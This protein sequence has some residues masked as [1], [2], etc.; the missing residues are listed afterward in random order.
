MKIC[1]IYLLFLPI[2]LANCSGNNNNH[3]EV[4]LQGKSYY[5]KGIPN[6]FCVHTKLGGVMGDTLIVKT[7]NDTHKSPINA[8]C[9]QLKFDRAGAYSAEFFL[10]KN[11]SEV[12]KLRE[13][14]FQV[15]DLPKPETFFN[16]DFLGKKITKEQL[17]VLPMLQCALINW[18][19]DIP[20][21]VKTFTGLF[22]T[23]KRLHTEKSDGSSWSNRQKALLLSLRKGDY[24]IIKD[25]IAEFPKGEQQELHSI[26][27][28]VF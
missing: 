21:E 25:I 1:K 23:N 22:L 16:L 10:K 2:V 14:I 15:K 26:V 13:A 9:F 3:T 8:P 7:V 12:V 6:L 20:C 4:F 24:L 28:E 11:N 5:F 27:V 19:I 17:K 18:D